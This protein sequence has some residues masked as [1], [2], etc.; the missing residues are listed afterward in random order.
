MIMR[1]YSKLY[2]NVK[3]LLDYKRVR[4]KNPE[5]LT[6]DNRAKR[7]LQSQFVVYLI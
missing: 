1:L 2:K 5:R 7:A 4:D 6:A 3:L